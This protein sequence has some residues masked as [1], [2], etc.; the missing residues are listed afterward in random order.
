[1]CLRI[2]RSVLTQ[3]KITKNVVFG[4]NFQITAVN[5]IY[6]M[7]VNIYCVS[8]SN[9]AEAVMLLGCMWETRLFLVFI[10]PSR[11]MLAG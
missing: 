8:L 3:C 11:R 2:L 4:G 6:K 9:L 1:M 7:S 5:E 10:D